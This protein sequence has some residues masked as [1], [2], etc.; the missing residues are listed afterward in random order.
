MLS[1]R[2]TMTYDV[3]IVGAGPA[4]LSA[5]CRL[6]QLAE[7]QDRAISVCVL[8][9][10]SRV[11]GHIL[12]GALLE[13]DFL[14][15]IGVD[16]ADAP[17]DAEV[18][19]ESYLLLGKED[20][21]SIPGPAAWSN[22]GNYLV[23]LGRL[24]RWLAEKAEAGGVEIYPG[25][26][27]V[28]L[29]MENNHVVGVRTGDMGRDK[30]GRP[31]ENFQPGMDIRAPIT[32][33]AEGCRGSLAGQAIH[34][35]GLN[36]NASPAT[37]ALGFKETWEVSS[38]MPGEVVHTLGYPLAESVHGG[39]YIYRPDR[40]HLALGLVIGLD[41]A[42]PRLDPFQ[43]F[44]KWKAHPKVRPFLEHGNLLSYGARTLSEGGWQSLPKLTFPGGML[45][46]DSAGFMD[47]AR[48]KGIGGA[49][50]SGRVAADVA[51]DALAQDDYS[52]HAFAAYSDTLKEGSYGQRLRAVSNVRPGFRWG[53]LVGMVNASLHA[54]SGEGREVKPHHWHRSDRR[55]LQQAEGYPEREDSA[56]DGIVQFDRATALSRAGIRHNSD[57][58]CH[59]KL[60]DPDY[61]LQEGSRQYDN[62]ELGY[63]PAGV[64]RK[65]DDTHY[66]IQHGDCLHCKTCEIK[67]P[68]KNILWTPPEGG[69]GPDYAEM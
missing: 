21:F 67:D 3:V 15:E 50:Y 27:A 7:S 56:Y 47:A 41:Y 69:S 28:D 62:P 53:R 16:P 49:I 14:L 60:F 52:D 35:F 1:H 46:G 37:Y 12:S 32:L 38:G 17:L 25:F 42:N 26:A 23:S 68:V 59:I 5:A 8:E 58:P 9:K 64:F 31:G 39:G 13:S 45:L 43:L 19:D 40:T 55:C 33:I 34:R 2:E 10:A 36:A 30:T 51:A 66:V 4:G 48:L 63:C 54:L 11:G 29:L 20:G 57:Q 65:T 22:K 44:Q 61:P 24:C 18:K 6:V